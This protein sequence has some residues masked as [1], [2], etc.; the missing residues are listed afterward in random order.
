MLSTL[1]A[2]A[3][4]AN[5]W[6]STGQPVDKRAVT[7]FSVSVKQQNL[8]QLKA[9]ALAVSTPGNPKHGKFMTE[10]QIAELTA[11]SAS[12]MKTVTSWLDTHHILYSV[13]NEL[14]KVSTTI[15]EAESLLG[16]KFYKVAHPDH[17]VKTISGEYSLPEG[18][19][20]ATAAVFGLRGLP[21]PKRVDLRGSGTVEGGAADDVTPAVLASTYSISGVSVKR[22]SSNV[23]AVAE[24]QGQLMNKSDLVNF[25]AHEVP[26]AQP[27]DEQVDKFVG[28]D[29][30]AGEGVEALL[31]IEFMMGVSPG[32]STQFWEWPNQDFC[33]DLANFTAHLLTSDVNVMSI[34]Y[35]WQG[36]LSVRAPP[37]GRLLHARPP[38]P[39]TPHA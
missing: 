26:T 17:G 39:A 7:E 3:G 24:F 33:A 20:R 9:N 34:S 25:F 15:G 13:S 21:L 36:N 16:T 29:Y 8:R 23:Q 14:I 28:V 35:G 11:P 1:V 27:G 6:T 30:S 37:N 22:G 19:G 4:L 18:V 12:D 32:I 31:D 10:R 5:Y 38:A 2:F